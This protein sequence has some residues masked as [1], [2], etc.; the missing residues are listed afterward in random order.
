MPPGGAARAAAGTGYLPRSSS[1]ACSTGI[2]G[3]HGVAGDPVHDVPIEIDRQAVFL[4]LG[5]APLQRENVV[6]TIG[7][8]HT[9]DQ[10]RAQDVAHLLAGHARLEEFDLLARYKIAL[11]H[12]ILVGVDQLARAV[13]IAAPGQQGSSHPGYCG[14]GEGATDAVTEHGRH[15]HEAND[16]IASL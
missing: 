14:Q 12:V 8:K 1:E 10:R 16:M 15:G 6:P 2:F 7:M 9:G 11:N 3:R 4:R 5:A 13:Q